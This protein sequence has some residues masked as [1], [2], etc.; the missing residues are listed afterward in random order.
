MKKPL[1]NGHGN[2]IANPVIAERKRLY[3]K[4]RWRNLRKQ[5]LAGNPMCSI[6]RVRHADTVDHIQHTPCNSRFFDRTN[7]RVACRSCNSKSAYHHNA[8][9]GGGTGAAGA[10]GDGIKYKSK[11]AAAP[12]QPC[13]NIS[14]K[15]SIALNLMARL[16]A[17]PK[18]DQTK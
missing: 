12:I 17:Q 10:G 8:A 16:R 13:K 9:T 4:Q 3:N 1:R 18:G 2:I 7:L 14:A 6:C 11:F 5:M 15:E